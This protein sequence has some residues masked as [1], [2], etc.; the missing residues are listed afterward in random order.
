MKVGFAIFDLS[1]VNIV[2]FCGDDVDFIKESFVISRDD[3]MM[4]LH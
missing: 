2:I 1:E 4:I 3:V